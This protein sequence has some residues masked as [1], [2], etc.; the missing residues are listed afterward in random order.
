MFLDDQLYQKVKSTELKSPEDFADLVNDLYKICEDY[1][2]SK[3]T[4]TITYKEG[5]QLMDKVFTF[6][7][8][9]INKLDKENWWLIDILKKEELSFRTT[10][11]KNEKLNEIYMKG[12]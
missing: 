8:M 6:W 2:K 12:K 11:L 4:D 10:Y 9:F 3:L 5:K 7:N 1:L